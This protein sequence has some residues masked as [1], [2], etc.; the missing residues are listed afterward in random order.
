MDDVR[1]TECRHPKKVLV[2]L[3]GAMLEQV[4][5]IAASECRTR[6]DLIRE[7]LRR[8]I[9]SFRSRGIA[10]GPTIGL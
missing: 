3:P 6:S 9:T 1:V 8:Y 2:A 10:P 7:S 5:H 4:D